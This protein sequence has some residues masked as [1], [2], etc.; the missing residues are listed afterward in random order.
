VPVTKLRAL[1][2]AQRDL[3]GGLRSKHDMDLRHPYRWAAFEL[4]GAWK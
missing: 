3:L 2:T 1:Q 4:Y